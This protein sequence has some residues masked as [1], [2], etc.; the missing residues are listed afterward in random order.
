M[1]TPMDNFRAVNGA[2]AASDAR[3]EQSGWYTIVAVFEV[4]KQIPAER[5]IH[6]R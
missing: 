4:K 3:C 5:L 1:L 2:Y 6:G